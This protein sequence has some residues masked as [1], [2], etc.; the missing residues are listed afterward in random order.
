[1]A[2]ITEVNPG[3]MLET[4][5]VAITEKAPAVGETM[6]AVTTQVYTSPGSAPAD[7]PVMDGEISAFVG[8]QNSVSYFIN[9]ELQDVVNYYR[10]QMPLN[11]W[12]ESATDSLLSEDVVEIKYVKGDRSAVVV[13]TEIPF[14]GQTTVVISID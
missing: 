3:G 12:Q 14:V 4:A 2:V 6:Q 1:M 7:I 5:Q 10:Q 9:A 13:L 8:S 11:G